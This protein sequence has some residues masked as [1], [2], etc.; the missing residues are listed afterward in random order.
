MPFTGYILYGKLEKKETPLK[1]G[2]EALLSLSSI[3]TVVGRFFI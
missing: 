3:Q 2:G 1:S